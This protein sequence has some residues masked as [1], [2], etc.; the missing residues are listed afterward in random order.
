VEGH[1][2]SGLHAHARQVPQRLDQR[3][4]GRFGQTLRKA[5]SCRGAGPR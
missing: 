5:A 4:E 3:L 2:R 1:A